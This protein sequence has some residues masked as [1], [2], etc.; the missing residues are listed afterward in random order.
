MSLGK[1]LFHQDAAAAAGDADAAQGLVLH[2]DAND[3][4]SIENGGANVGNGSGTWFDIST[5]DLNV[6]RIAPSTNLILDLDFSNTAS[7]SGSGPV[8]DVSPNNP[9]ANGTINGS[10]TFASDTR[11]YYDFGSLNSNFISIGSLGDFST[12]SDLSFEVW[13]YPQGSGQQALFAT[14][15]SSTSAGYIFGIAD[16]GGRV[17]NFSDRPTGSFARSTTSQVL[18]DQWQHIVVTW[19]V[20]EKKFTMYV[21]GTITGVS[22][23]IGSGTATTPTDSN[24]VLKLNAENT[25]YGSGAWQGRFNSLRIYNRVLTPSEVAQN[26]RADCLLSFSSIYNTN[27]LIDYRPSNYSGSGTSITN[28]GT[29]SNDAVLTGGVESTYDKE[30]DD[31]FTFDGSSNTGDGIE[32]TSN[33]TGVNLNTDGFSWEIWVNI[34]SDSY[35]YI[36]SFNYSSTYYNFSYRSDSNK[37]SFFNLGTSLNT[38]ALDL[39][40]WYHIV[41]TADSSGTKLYT[42]GVLSDSNGTAAPNHNL[43][44]KIYF[45]TYWGHNSAQHIHTGLIGD[46][47]FHKGALSAAQVAQNYIATKNNYP[48]GHNATITGALFGTNSL[49][50]NEKRFTLSG[51]S[52]YFTVP[53]NSLFNLHRD[54]SLE[55][56][57]RRT[58][59]TSDMVLAYKGSSVSNQWFIVWNSSSGYYYYNYDTTSSTKSGTSSTPINTWHHFVLAWNVTD[60]KAKMFF[61]GAEPSPYNVSPTDGGGTVGTSNT[62]DFEIGK[63]N[64]VTVHPAFVGEIAMVKWYDKELNATESLAK[65]N[66]TKATFGL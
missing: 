3:E 57:L 22:P 6:P 25:G 19:D 60:R 56:W 50:P 40:E 63:A 58:G 4:D 55:M 29:L 20:S 26:F 45:G 5:H 36:T 15:H 59:T 1:K 49:S 14:S 17:W 42:D 9:S 31:F 32:T 43:N 7:Y 41:G 8:N 48:N 38:P 39:N 12:T 33:V 46:A 18:N 11:G 24:D 51:S 64:G 10:G 47:R 21:D 66:A 16:V 30:L 61:N 2:L 65:Y 35:S 44:S 23:N 37:V 62:S 13:A 53:H 28:L 34:T 54:G 52:Q 27:A